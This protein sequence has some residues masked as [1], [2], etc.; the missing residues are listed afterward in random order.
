VSFQIVTDDRDLLHKIIA[1][2]IEKSPASRIAARRVGTKWKVIACT[3]SDRDAALLI[4]LDE[5]ELS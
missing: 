5:A 3:L 2:F 1:D 4:P